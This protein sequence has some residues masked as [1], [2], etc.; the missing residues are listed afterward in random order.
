M[1]RPWIFEFFGALGEFHE[2]FDDPGLRQKFRWL[3]AP[4]SPLA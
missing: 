3:S 2:R 4:P 1:I